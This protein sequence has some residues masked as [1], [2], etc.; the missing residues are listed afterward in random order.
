MKKLLTRIMIV[1]IVCIVIPFTVIK[2]TNIKNKKANTITESGGRGISTVI[3]NALQEETTITPIK[4]KKIKKN[5]CNNQN[6]LLGGYTVGNVNVRKNNSVNSDIIGEIP[7]NTYIEYQKYDENWGQIKYNNEIGY[8]NIGYIAK[9]DCEYKSYNMPTNSGFKSYMSYKAITDKS[10][11]QYQLQQLAL[12]S[13]DGI[14]CISDRY[15]VAI[16]T[17]FDA[18]VGTYVDLVLTNDLIIPCVVGDIKADVDTDST[19][20]VTKHNGCVAEFIVDTKRLN[21]KAKKMGD[22][23]YCNKD[24]DKPIKSIIIYEK[25]ILN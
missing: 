13:T 7:F 17:A 4:I 16:G 20:I 15:C 1:L 19:N 11:A 18:K 22:M 5:T 21:K 6:I 8:I 2:I 10:S 25:N 23:S 9:E 3:E 14:R 12:T 24:W